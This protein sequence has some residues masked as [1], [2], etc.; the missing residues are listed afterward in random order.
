[1]LTTE[2][3]RFASLDAWHGPV[4]DLIDQLFDPALN[5][6]DVAWLRD[7]WKA[8]LII[9]G[10]QTADDARMVADAGADAIVDLEPRLAASSIARRS[11]SSSC[12]TSSRRSATASRSISTAG[13]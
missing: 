7:A 12:R 2:P 5:L 10:I 6:K 11:R 13:S 3:L 8:P 1:M 9:K 4:A